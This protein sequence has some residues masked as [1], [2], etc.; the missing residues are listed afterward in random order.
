MDDLVLLL[1]TET[2][3]EWAGWGW[4]KP[5]AGDYGVVS[6]AADST[7]Q[8]DERNTERIR[9]GY[10]DYFTRTTGDVAKAAIETAL[11]KSG[12]HW[13]NTGVDYE[14]ETGFV[15]LSWRVAWD[16]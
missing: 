15:H 4:A 2:G 13:Y 11:N 9:E 1:T 6:Y 10:V 16:A 7:F 12:L 5:P 14:R 3:Y 8:A